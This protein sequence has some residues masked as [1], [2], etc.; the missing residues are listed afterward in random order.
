MWGWRGVALS[1][2]EE[3]SFE[4]SDGVRVSRKPAEQRVDPGSAW[5]PAGNKLAKKFAENHCVF[6]CWNISG[7]ASCLSPHGIPVRMA[8]GGAGLRHP[9]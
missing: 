4:L 1:P 6:F 3:E 7:C 9:S 5:S 2:D 8:W